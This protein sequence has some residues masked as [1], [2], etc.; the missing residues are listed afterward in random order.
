LQINTVALVVGVLNRLI[1]L[2]TTEKTNDCPSQAIAP[3]PHTSLLN[4]YIQIANKMG[5]V[6][7]VEGFHTLIKKVML[8]CVNG[9]VT[10]IKP[11][12]GLIITLHGRIAAREYV[13]RLCN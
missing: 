7:S 4:V 6:V 12:V 10:P 3:N 13:D 1:T 2:I 5:W 8:R 9:S 11:A